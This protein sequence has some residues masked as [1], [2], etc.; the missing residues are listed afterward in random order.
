MH[1]P[2]NQPTKKIKREADKN[3]SISR[4]LVFLY[5]FRVTID[6]VDGHTALGSVLY[7]LRHTHDNAVATQQ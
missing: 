4:S 3:H 1:K 5:F 2:T 7:K 6:I